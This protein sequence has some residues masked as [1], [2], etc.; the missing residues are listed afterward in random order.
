M[1]SN[2]LSNSWSRQVVSNNKN[3]L[4]VR[5]KSL[6]SDWKTSIGRLLTWLFSPFQLPPQASDILAHGKLGQGTCATIQQDQGY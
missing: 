2:V 1:R 5:E 3:I 4:Y 6:V